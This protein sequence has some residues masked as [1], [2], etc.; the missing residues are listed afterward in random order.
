M[1]DNRSDCGV[2]GALTKRGVLHGRFGLCIGR[3]SHVMTARLRDP[4][5]GIP[6]PTS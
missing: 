1:I 2:A 4:G 3:D 6:S 5:V